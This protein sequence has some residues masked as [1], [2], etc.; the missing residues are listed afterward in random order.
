[1]LMSIAT[2]IWIAPTTTNTGGKTSKNRSTRTAEVGASHLRKLCP[3][4]NAEITGSNGKEVKGM[5]MVGAARLSKLCPIEAKPQTQINIL[6]R[7]ARAGLARLAPSTPSIIR[8]QGG[9][10][11]RERQ[12]RETVESP[13]YNV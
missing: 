7:G 3:H 1:M 2:L 5:A 10:G 4:T 13:P 11:G 9:Q 6:I 12:S 8:K